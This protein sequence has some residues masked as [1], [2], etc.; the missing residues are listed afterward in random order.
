MRECTVFALAPKTENE[1]RARWCAVCNGIG[2]RLIYMAKLEGSACRNRSLPQYFQSL[3]RLMHVF[4]S[5]SSSST[6]HRSG[7]L[8]RLLIVP[9]AIVIIVVLVVILI[10]PL[11]V[12]PLF[13]TNLSGIRPL[14]F[15]LQIVHRLDLFQKYFYYS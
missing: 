3:A 2:N 1:K 14:F 12:V 11:L 4:F 7:P 13:P 15:P 5:S 10:I 9:D 8:F 6:F